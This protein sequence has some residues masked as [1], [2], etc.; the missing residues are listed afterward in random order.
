MSGSDQIREE[1]GG[2]VIPAPRNRRFNRIVGGMRPVTRLEVKNTWRPIREMRRM[3]R[4]HDG[5][6]S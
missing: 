6:M 1:A 2:F 5:R 4:D 3:R